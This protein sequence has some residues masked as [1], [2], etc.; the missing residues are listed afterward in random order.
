MRGSELTW[1]VAV[2]VVRLSGDRGRL[3]QPDEARSFTPRA[4]AM[5]TTMKP[6]R[7]SIVEGVRMIGY[8][9]LSSFVTSPY[10]F[11]LTNEALDH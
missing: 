3:Y 4:M 10:S 5:V 9:N 1:I 6:V 8:W 7:K 2:F 11:Q